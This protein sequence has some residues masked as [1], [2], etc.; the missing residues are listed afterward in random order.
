MNCPIPLLPAQGLGGLALALVCCTLYI[1]RRRPHVLWWALSWS[2]FVGWAWA[3][4]HLLPGGE[5]G[6]PPSAMWLGKG[7][8]EICLGWHAALW[9][10]GL[11]SYCAGEPSPPTRFL[12][13]G[14]VLVLL[15]AGVAALG[16][17]ALPESAGAA[18]VST[19]LAT[20]YGSSAALLGWDRRSNP[21]AGWLALALTLAALG[22]IGGAAVHV[23]AWRGLLLPEALAAAWTVEAVGLV[24]LAAGLVRDSAARERD[25]LH[26][27]QRRLG[28]AEDHFRLI[29]EHGGVGMALLAPD[30]RF[31]RVNAALVR[32]LGHDHAAL[33]GRRLV[34]FAHP[35]DTRHGISPSEQG[36]AVPADQYERQ[37]RYRHR[38]GHTVWAQ[39]VR[40]P[41]RDVTGTLR[42]LVAV[43][44]DI[45]ERHRAEEALAE[46]E[47]RYRLCF[48]RAFDGL[49][50][51]TEGG[52]VLDVNPAFGR[53]VGYT[54]EELGRLTVA[55]LADDLPEFRRH[56]TAVLDRGGD[57]FEARLR[58][59]DGSAVEAEI[60]GVVIERGGRR[61]VHHIMRDVSARKRAEEALHR[62]Q[63]FTEQILATADAL[64]LVLDPSGQVERFGGACPTV[65]GYREEEARGQVF[66]DFLV[67]PA[68]RET[69]RRHFN[70][71][72]GEQVPVAFESALAVRGGG[73]RWI[74]WRF[75]A[76]RDTP[77]RL[78]HVIAAGLDVTEQRRLEEQ[79]RQ[80]QKMETLGTLVGGIAHDFNNQLT[81]ILGNLTLARA[82]AA[83]DGTAI[84]ELADAEA[85]AQRCADMTQSL[86]TFS[87]RRIPRPQM[88]D[89]NAVVAEAARLM[90][91]LLPA[92]ICVKVEA[93]TGPTAVVGDRTQLHQVLINLAVNA[94]DAMP[95]GG[96]LMLATAGAVVDTA[97]C[98]RN[99]EARP[100]DF[101]VLTVAD[102]G[103]GMAPEVRSH[104]FEPFFTTKPV[105][106]GTGLGLAVVYGIVKAH[107]GWIS[108]TSA[109]GQGTTFAVYLPVAPAEAAHAAEAGPPPVRGGRECVL[110]VDDEDMVRHLARC[111]LER[112]GFQVL[113]A[114]DGEQALTT[115]RSR[116][117]EID[118][119]VLDFAMPHMTGLEVLRN[120]RRLNPGV[121]VI[122]ASGYVDSPESETLLIAG[123]RAFVPKP[124]RPEELIRRVRQV[125]DEPAPSLR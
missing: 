110:V 59:K 121:R 43:F 39:V 98:V 101:L 8:A 109:P 124:Y 5:P 2:C 78:R 4:A 45:T 30:G 90:Q 9:L 120:L 119:V 71:V 40:V 38:D 48:E 42:Y 76:A 36:L 68:V 66:W 64:I 14:Q 125:L 41:L 49:F 118:L 91:R 116:G 94:R 99:V 108:V 13:T 1:Q 20:V 89:L 107:G 7:A 63:E 115:Y 62:E 54:A 52:E 81:I 33:E 46:S 87:R 88:L 37:R 17:G 15:A 6:S 65:S 103:T 82:D 83:P 11:R 86:L 70:R 112:W 24:L 61:V 111:V 55:D 28:E 16:L 22:R 26:S 92:T 75:T 27:T 100:G 58:R 84:R 85:A 74:A 114:A 77:G 23:A 97:Y 122:F 60:S 31:L 12:E 105:G 57:C 113:T 32:F 10:F 95:T 93:E 80:A 3:E 19:V 34:D 69:V 21:T 29:F 53:M 25:L 102:T 47:E 96:T 106:Q 51:C 44:I 123:A 104:L 117:P 50:C 79:L 18:L 56:F 73:E 35:E 72:V 67:P